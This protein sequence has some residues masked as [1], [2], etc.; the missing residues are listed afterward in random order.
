MAQY[1]N[2]TRSSNDWKL[3][4]HSFPYGESLFVLLVFL[5]GLKIQLRKP[6]RQRNVK[7]IRDF[8][9]KM[10]QLMSALLNY[11]ACIRYLGN[12]H[13][14]KHVRNA[15]VVPYENKTIPKIDKKHKDKHPWDIT[16]EIILERQ[17]AALAVKWAIIPLE[18]LMDEQFLK[19]LHSIEEITDATPLRDA[20]KQL[21]K[22]IYSI[23][24]SQEQMTRISAEL[25]DQLVFDVAKTYY[26]SV[27][28]CLCKL[29]KSIQQGQRTAL[30]SLAKI[31][32]DQRDEIEG[33]QALLKLP[34]EM[35]QLQQEMEKLKKHVNIHLERTDKKTSIT[36]V[37]IS[38]IRSQI[39]RPE[40]TIE[41]NFERILEPDQ[42]SW[43]F[44]S[45]IVQIHAPENDT[46][47]CKE[48]EEQVPFN[49]HQQQDEDSATG[50]QPREEQDNTPQRLS[51]IRQYIPAGAEGGESS[52]S[53]STCDE[54]ETAEEGL[55]RFFDNPSYRAAN[56]ALLN[57]VEPEEDWGDTP[58]GLLPISIAPG[59]PPPTSRFE[60]RQRYL[61]RRRE[62][63]RQNDWE[64]DHH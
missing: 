56:P 40:A 6:N 12:N 3:H 15:K 13:I 44:P 30:V 9:R 37:T 41:G 64:R 54:E 59:P 60:K 16:Q 1:T 33:Y 52:P 29:I 27:I 39:H 25:T 23:V 20:A 62:R 61:Q 17:R 55:A 28:E 38:E 57:P 26:Y 34:A 11:C 5:Y 43:V 48:F 21:P 63:R 4:F 19:I 18:V 31:V 50:G 22:Q 32:Q 45:D 8:W 51:P 53:S 7:L 36:L 35:R 2:S 42:P 49:E 10:V 46:L 24:Q 14:K 47:F 58:P